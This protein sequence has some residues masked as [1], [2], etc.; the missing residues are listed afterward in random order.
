LENN[1]FVSVTTNTCF[2]FKDQRVKFPKRWRLLR[3]V[4]Q[5]EHT[6]KQTEL[7]GTVSQGRR[8]RIYI[9]VDQCNTYKIFR[10]LFYQRCAMLRCCRCIWIPSIIFIGTKLLNTGGNRITKLCFLY[11]KMRTMNACC[12]W[13]PYLII[14]DT[15][16]TRV[17]H[18]PLT[19][20]NVLYSKTSAHYLLDKLRKRMHASN[21]CARARDYGGENRP[22]T[23][24][25]L[26]EAGESVRLLLTKDHPVPTTAFRA[27]AR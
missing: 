20:L 2:S 13:L 12:G 14:I 21:R 17:A 22:V 10:V 6:D 27:G 15:P 8:A 5:L 23:S 1:I 26:G 7:V 25:A 18:L 16:Y 11:E 4:T 9:K 3:P 24:P 19:M